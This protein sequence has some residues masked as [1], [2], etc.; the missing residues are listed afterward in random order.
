MQLPRLL[1]PAILAILLL[2][3]LSDAKRVSRPSLLP[4]NIKYS[5]TPK[6]GLKDFLGLSRR[7][8]SNPEHLVARHTEACRATDSDTTCTWRASLTSTVPQCT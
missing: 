1:L 3:S 5:Y 4:R 2:V 7:S 8:Q 6:P